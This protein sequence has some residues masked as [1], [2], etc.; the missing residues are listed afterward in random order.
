MLIICMFIDVN[1]VLLTHSLPLQG[2]GKSLRALDL[3][4]LNDVVVVLLT[5]RSLSKVWHGPKSLHV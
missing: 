1:V 3:H 2:C 4:V 5:L